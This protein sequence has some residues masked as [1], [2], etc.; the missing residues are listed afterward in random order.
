MDL[1][2]LNWFQQEQLPLARLIDLQAFVSNSLMVACWVVGGNYE[3][4]LY[5]AELVSQSSL[6]YID[7]YKMIGFVI[8]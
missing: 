7:F 3:M 8:S 5:A 4:E 2:L 6:S 1:F